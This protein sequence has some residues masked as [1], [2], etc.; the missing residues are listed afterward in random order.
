MADCE[1]TL[2]EL[3]AFLDTELSPEAHHA[4]Q[5]HLDDCLHCLHTF[6]FHAELRQVIATKCANDEMPS[7]L[8]DR[9]QACFGD[10]DDELENELEA[11]APPT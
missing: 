5:Q 6:D 1:D 8:L 3:E 10:L 2:R 9:I 11:G 7:G 4:V